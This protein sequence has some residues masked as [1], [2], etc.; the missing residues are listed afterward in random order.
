M[1]ANGVYKPLDFFGTAG[2]RLYMLQPYD[3]K[4]RPVIFVH[5]M[6]GSPRSFRKMIDGLD[7]ARFQPWVFYWPTGMPVEISGWTLDQQVE[8]LCYRDGFNACDVVGYSMGGLVTRTALNI[9]AKEGRPLVVRHFISLSTPWG[10]DPAATSGVRHSP[11]VV[12]SWRNMD[13]T[14]TYMKTLF[15]QSWPKDVRYTLFF[16]YGGGGGSSNADGVVLLKSALVADAENHA[17]FIYGFNADHLSI[18]TD[19][20]VIEKLNEELET[21]V[22]AGAFPSASRR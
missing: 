8:Y 5:G 22:A 12:P 19:H 16:G 18:V 20:E 4:R 21:P 14:G 10:G 15:D 6:N 13:P 7:K 2:P 11:V 17:S 9:R 3:S 1:V